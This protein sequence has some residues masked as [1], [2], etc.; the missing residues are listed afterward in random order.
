MT[1]LSDIESAALAM[2][3]SE[4]QA[5]ATALFSGLED[6]TISAHCGVV[7]KLAYL[8][9]VAT[10]TALGIGAEETRICVATYDALEALQDG[11]CQQAID[12]DIA[13]AKA[14]LAYLTP[15]E[16]TEKIA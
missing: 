9:D 10:L 14:A 15:Y 5:I 8:G 6:V 3:I 1:L 13:R 12:G 4:D 16:S 2:L 11:H 7:Q